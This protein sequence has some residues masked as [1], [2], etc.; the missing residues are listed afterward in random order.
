M[1]LL[2]THFSMQFIWLIIF[3]KYANH[4]CRKYLSISRFTKTSAS[5]QQPHGHGPQHV[6]S[7]IF[8]RTSGKIGWFLACVLGSGCWKEAVSLPWVR[9]GLQALLAL[10]RRV[11]AWPWHPSSSTSIRICTHTA[12]SPLSVWQLSRSPSAMHRISWY[13]HIGSFLSSLS[14]AEFGYIKGT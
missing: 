4:T 9:S 10:S 6:A 13:V 8:K 5:L 14:T 12:P 3:F 11:R 1:P 7:P 2:Y